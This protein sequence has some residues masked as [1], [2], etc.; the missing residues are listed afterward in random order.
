[1]RKSGFVFLLSFL[2]AA[3][4]ADS[5]NAQSRDEINRRLPRASQ[6][7]SPAR[8]KLN[9]LKAQR[10]A[11][12]AILEQAIDPAEY[13]VGPGDLFYIH[14]PAFSEND[15][16]AAVTAE[17]RL[18]I[19]T[20]GVFDVAGKTLAALQGQLQQLGQDK[21]RGNE[22]ILTLLS[23][24]FFRVHVTGEVF[25]A[26]IYEVQQLHR[27]SDALTLAGGLTG[28]GDTERIE[29][30]RQQSSTQIVDFTGY[31][32]EGLLDANPRL[33]DGD[34]VHVPQIDKNA[35]I[36]KVEGRVAEPGLYAVKAGESAEAFLRRNFGGTRKTDLLAAVVKRPINADSS[37]LQ[38]KQQYDEYAIFSLRDNKMANGN[39]ADRQPLVLQS[40]DIVSIPS[41]VDSVYVQG[42]V[43]FPGAYP[44]YPG[45]LARD[46][47]GL[48]GPNE[49]AAG[50]T[51]IKVRHVA[52]QQIVKGP[53]V[54]VKPGD[55][56]EVRSSTRLI[57]R[58]YVQVL[59]AVAGIAWTF[60]LI[61]NS[62]SNE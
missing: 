47:A 50:M 22:I 31:L 30:R 16:Q 26:G 13:I 29:I 15:Q 3:L 20:F 18:I 27:L 28:W 8:D 25:E 19:P 49:H 10:A 61:N 53:D 12:F 5:A 40:G 62:L 58:D 48:A 23:P 37:R 38:K 9:Q 33:L 56:V 32:A 42:A 60:A 34:V 24:R 1:M 41:V 2:A 4:L 57:I 21:F 7:Q 14:F 52:T 36:V 6:Q 54:P 39:S 44:Y 55:T 45:F 43:N 11:D 35:A 59:A 51:G 17:G 46:Y